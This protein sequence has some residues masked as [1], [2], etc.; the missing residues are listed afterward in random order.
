MQDV[1]KKK[2]TQDS[3]VGLTTVSRLAAKGVLSS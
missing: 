2:K 1:N 3:L